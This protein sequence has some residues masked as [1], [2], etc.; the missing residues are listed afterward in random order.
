MARNIAANTSAVAPPLPPLHRP[1]AVICLGEAEERE[2]KKGK[3][4]AK[5][6]AY[7]KHRQARTFSLMFAGVPHAVSSPRPDPRPRLVH[8]PV[9]A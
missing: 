2:R 4:R 6:Y 5:A 3:R 1:G 9:M 8:Q 7:E